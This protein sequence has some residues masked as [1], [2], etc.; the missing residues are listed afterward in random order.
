MFQKL[1]KNCFG[2]VFIDVEKISVIS[3]V[4]KL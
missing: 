4:E 1:C 3:N 2:V